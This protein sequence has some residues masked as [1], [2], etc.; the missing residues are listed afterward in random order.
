M[1]TL[2]IVVL[3]LINFSIYG[4]RNAISIAFQPADFGFGIR[5]NRVFKAIGYYG[6]LSYGDWGVYRHNY[7]S[8]HVKASIGVMVPLADNVHWGLLYGNHLFFTC[9]INYHYIGESFG[10][11]AYLNPKIFN[12]WSFELG[13]AV[14]TY[15]R[16]ALGLRT[17]ILRWEPC[18]DIGFR[19]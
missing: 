11:N 17:D 5:Y 12:P 15:R 8:D 7:L 6:S 16:F 13:V 2:L 3:L 18:V 4:Q 14:Y 9:G 1:K 19:F 10:D